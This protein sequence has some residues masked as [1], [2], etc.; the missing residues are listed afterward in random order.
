MAELKKQLGLGDV[1]CICAGAMISSGLFVLPAIIYSKAG[2]SVIL[3]YF[4]ASIF[5]IPSVFSKA[6]LATAM[7]RA[8]GTYFYIERSLGPL[9]GFFSGLAN[10]F[11]VALKSAFALIGAAV[12]LR[13]MIGKA[14]GVQA[15]VYLKIIAAL[16]CTVFMV[17][18]IFSVKHSSRFQW[19]L[20][21]LLLA[22]L[23][24]F[25]LYGLKFVRPEGFS[26]FFKEPDLT[27]R[28]MPLLASVGMVFVSFGGLTKVASIAEE[29]R[30]PNRDLPAGM[31]LAWAVVTILY[32]GTVSVTVGV[33]N[34]AELSGSLTPISTAAEVFMGKAGFII[35][36][37]AA[38]AAFVTTANAGI[39][40]A[41]R[42]PMA[43]S[44]DRLLP[45]FLA[46]LS[47]KFQT[48]YVSIILTGG[49][50]IAA[51]V[52]L[53]IESLVKTASALMIMLFMLTNLS[54]IIMRASRIQS[55][56]PK[57]RSPGYPYVHILAIIVYGFLIV[58]MGVKPLIITM[59]FIVLSTAWY[60]LY[61]HRRVYRQSAIM[62]IVERVTDKELKTVTLE[63]ELRD[64]LLA[65]DNI[66]EDRFDE[67]IR[68]CDIV[69][70]TGKESADEVFTTVSKILVD[71]IGANEKQLKD[72]FHQREAEG[73]TVI[74]PGLAIPHIVVDGQN[75]FDIVLVRAVEGIDFPHSET[76]VQAM[77][78][79]VGSKDER[80]YHLRAL[81]AIAQ[82]AQEKDFLDRWREAR[83]LDGIRNLLLLSKRT[84]DE[85]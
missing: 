72:K 16:C 5:V 61:A 10:W 37:I 59:A 17:L 57:F 78:V 35:L 38:M 49:F 68:V 45:G 19:I 2:G 28:L 27:S 29:V 58:D 81:M 32:L 7:P 30:R 66:I 64:I 12:F 22:V 26:P 43:M 24:V 55:Y 3:V 85:N 56:R 74:M 52:F 63:N 36:G 34:S 8:G 73:S 21:S 80:N 54:V 47:D 84:R 1:F 65:R 42:Y 70:V 18:N 83:G 60:L 44:R 4:L 77:F 31:I 13:L 23:S 67:L 50:M 39:M 14:E 62:H 51:I 69:D 33:L 82:I 48:P 79:L 15:D 25:V 9:W 76:P 75:K 53:D 40:T 11:S 20:V 71:Q 41:S 46:K 6:E